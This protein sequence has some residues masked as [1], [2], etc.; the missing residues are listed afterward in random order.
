MPALPS[1]GLAGDPWRK[2]V[3]DLRDVEELRREGHEAVD[4]SEVGGQPEGDPDRAAGGHADLPEVVVE[5]HAFVVLRAD[6]RVLGDR[7]RGLPGARVAEAA[8]ADRDAVVRRD[9]VDETLVDH[10]AV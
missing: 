3:R 1:A 10:G 4:V 9:D 2:A 8:G 7:E 6:K 5:D